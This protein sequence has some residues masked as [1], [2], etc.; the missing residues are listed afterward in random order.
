MG[1]TGLAEGGGVNEVEMMSDELAEGRLAVLCGVAGEERVVVIG[2][3][4]AGVME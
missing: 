4:I 1:G 2:G 3:V